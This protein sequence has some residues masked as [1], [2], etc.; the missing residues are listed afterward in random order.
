MNQR[1]H[2]GSLEVGIKNFMQ[3]TGRDKILRILDEMEKPWID[4][5]MK[6]RP[7]KVMDRP[8]PVCGSSKYRTAFVKD[9]F[10]HIICSQCSMMYVSPILKREPSEDWFRG[11]VEL[12]SWVDVLLNENQRKFD[13]PKFLR[14]MKLLE[15]YSTL[16]GRRLL[17]IGCAVGNFLLI[18]RMKGWKGVGLELTQKA[19]DYCESINLD[20]RQEILTPNTFQK[21]SFD[22]VTMWDVLEHILDP[23]EILGTIYNV[24]K[25]GGLLL[26]R[27]PNGDSL[28]ARILQE[29][30]LVF[31]GY[32]H[33]SLFSTKTLRKITESS[34]FKTIS[35]E[36]VN[37]ELNVINNYLQYQDPY[38]GDSIGR[39]SIL[40]GL[41]DEDELFTRD[42]GYS[43][44]TIVKRID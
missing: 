8:C 21:G 18:A 24:L 7:E 22:V 3:S 37:P 39:G 34:G 28:A 9:G 4:E 27:V 42:L 10:P 40:D 44:F 25:P 35:I 26:L 43:I 6:L 23:I 33:V 31:A 16:P 38:L 20:V 14:G 29:K 12:D 19:V 15:E 13:E 32:T 36:T 5:S 17:D 1:E 41:I 2:G 30:C 11:S